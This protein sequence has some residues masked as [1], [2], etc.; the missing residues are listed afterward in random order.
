MKTFN[1][2]KLM[3]KWIDA[4]IE[5]LRILCPYI[6]VTCMFALGVYIHFYL[7]ANESKVMHQYRAQIVDMQ[8]QIDSLNLSNTEN[9]LIVKAGEYHITQ[10]NE[11]IHL[12]K[13][14]AAS[15]L[16]EIGTW[17]PDIIM[18]QL[19]IESGFGVSDVAVKANNL[20]GM[21]K[22]NRRKTT[23]I[24]NMNYNGYGVYNNWE[25]SVIDRVLW[26]YE[27]FNG[28]K[29]SRRAYIEK[30]N[31]FYG[32]HGDYGDVMDKHSKQ[33]AKYFK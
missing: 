2:N 6:I 15:L 19:Q 21:K 30:L 25:S 29:P 27:F 31:K 26:D 17:Y 7:N 28:K 32:G 10:H 14:S 9:A 16:I 24:K 3:K 1:F 8:E 33:F 12:S 20:A 5:K 23:Q 4:V 13:D 18:A 11:P 22:T